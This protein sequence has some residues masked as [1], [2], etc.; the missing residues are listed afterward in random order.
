[1]NDLRHLGGPLGQ[2]P[3]VGGEYG[4][5]QIPLPQT[6]QTNHRI[7]AVFIAGL[8]NIFGVTIF[9]GFGAAVLNHRHGLGIRVL[10]AGE[11]SV[12]SGLLASLQRNNKSLTKKVERISQ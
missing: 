1:M 2:R 11:E 5:Q 8:L 4:L 3:G 6:L 10:D 9:D 7:L 12:S